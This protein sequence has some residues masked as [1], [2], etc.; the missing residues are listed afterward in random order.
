MKQTLNKDTFRFLM[1]EI[2]PDNFSYEGLGILF[3]YFEQ[4]EEDTDDQIEFDPI[5]FC[6]EYAESDPQEIANDLDFDEDEPC[7]GMDEEETA[8]FIADKL[9]EKTTVLGITS[10]NQIV[11]QQY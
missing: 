7:H 8:Q 4:Y 3:D 6:C 11:Y 9:S 10:D 2:R 1:Y 5:A